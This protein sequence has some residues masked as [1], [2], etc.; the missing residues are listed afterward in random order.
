[1]IDE[2]MLEN[3]SFILEGISIS[4]DSASIEDVRLELNR[5]LISTALSTIPREQYLP[6]IGEAIPALL[7]ALID[8]KAIELSNVTL[9]IKGTLDAGA[10]ELVNLSL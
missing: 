8:G 2:L 5:E 7:G 3:G 1:M 6:M 4:F 10:S 9:G